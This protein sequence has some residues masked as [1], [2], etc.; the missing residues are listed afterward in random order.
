MAKKQRKPKTELVQIRVA[1][2]VKAD[3]EAAADRERRNLSDW[4]RLAAEDRA[5]KTNASTRSTP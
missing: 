1:P 3:W 2:D 4:V 5:Q